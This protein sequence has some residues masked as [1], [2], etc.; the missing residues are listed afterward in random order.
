MVSIMDL[1]A[2]D[3]ENED[4][5]GRLPPIPYNYP[6]AYQGPPAYQ[7]PPPPP[8]VFSSGRGFPLSQYED[9]KDVL[10][11]KTRTPTPP[12]PAKIPTPTGFGKNPVTPRCN[13]NHSLGWRRVNP[14]QKKYK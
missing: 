5:G 10:S 6:R 14:D 11:Y 4:Y 3:D 8:P 1:Q 2:P 13:H 9:N 7:Q 12:V